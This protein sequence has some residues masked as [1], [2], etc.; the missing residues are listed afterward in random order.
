MILLA[1]LVALALE[2]MVGH[3]PMIGQPVVLRWAILDLHR[4]LPWQAYWRSA[5]AACLPLIL[6]MAGVHL[7][8]TLVSGVI[9]DLV[10]SAGVLLL[11]LGPRDLG[12]DIKELIEAREADDV[13]REK[14][15]TRVL[16]RV[17]DR[18]RSRRSLIGA[19]F[20]QSHERL[21]GVLPWF[22][23]LGP[24]G[25]AA[26]RVVSHL[27]RLF[28]RIE[29]DT[30]AERAAVLLHA[31]FAWI[32]TR[33]TALMYLLSGSTDSALDG[34]RRVNQHPDLDWQQRTWAR[35]AETA[36]GALA[37]EIVEG[38]PSVSADLDECLREVIELQGRALLVLL[39]GFAV[40]TTGNW[41]A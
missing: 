24:A 23:R 34:W 15:L 38:A 11:C 29:P 26:Y 17:P 16:L 37:V 1:V 14:E 27:P 21:F 32:P 2:R 33:V 3:V 13:A 6:A 8:D 7:L 10:F 9:A 40:F 5:I 28:H 30:Q 36:A 18:R 39:A 22:F 31:A 12:V 35:L 41:I 4:L 25:A 19:L 20:I